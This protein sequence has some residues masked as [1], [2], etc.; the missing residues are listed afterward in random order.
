MQDKHAHFTDP[1]AVASYATDTPR[2]V[3]GLADLHRMVALLLAEQAPAEARVLVVGAGGGLELVSLATAQP[4]WRFTGVDPSVAMLDLARQAAAAF[5]ERVQL[6]T[7][8]VD[9]VPVE[10]FDGATC[11]LTLHFLDRGERLRTLREIHR[12]LRPGAR[13]IVAHH[14]PPGGNAERW[15]ARSVAFGA[16]AN[17]DQAGTAAAGRL[18][19]QRLPLLTPRE[20]EELLRD[21]GFVDVEMFYAAF[22]FRGWV[23]TRGFMA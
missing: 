8:I 5:A 4:H 3:P 7:G 18:M 12:R 17:P 14:A 21:A 6:V 16:G 23:G 15:M 13:L 11:L 19:T 2:K 9:Q 10:P 22:S 1:A 20:E